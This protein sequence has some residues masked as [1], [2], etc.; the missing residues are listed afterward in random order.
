[1]NIFKRNNKEHDPYSFDP[2][3]SSVS[4]MVVLLITLGLSYGYVLS[5]S[6]K[7]NSINL[8]SEINSGQE[9]GLS[10]YVSP[11]PQDNYYLLMKNNAIVGFSYQKLFWHDNYLVG[12]DIISLPDSMYLKRTNWKAANNLANW[13]K[14]STTTN[15]ASGV[16]TEI[17]SY[18]Q[19]IISIIKDR[20]KVQEAPLKLISYNYVPDFLIDI[21]SSIG[22]QKYPK[23]LSFIID[24]SDPDHMSPYN[25]KEASKDDIPS[26][27]RVIDPESIAA[28][29]RY[30]GINSIVL[31][32]SQHRLLY[33]Q[34]YGNSDGMSFDTVTI[35]DR[36]SII[37][38]WP[39][40]KY[41]LPE[42][43]PSSTATEI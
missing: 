35:S 5:K 3:R 37:E 39:E 28:E 43:E 14:Q 17:E 31:F 34:A 36:K 2:T 32:D 38:N 27:V 10:N 22:M 21:V 4:L 11:A 1:M 13:V 9:Y 33:Q 15:N 16:H 40:A 23:G 41:V 24:V 12:A 7:T 20:R 8:I 6:K 42:D 29:A 25:I 30:D 19:G 26:E 18:S